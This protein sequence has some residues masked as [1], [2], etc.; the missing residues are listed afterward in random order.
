MQF[1][2]ISDDS[3]Y[4][5]VLVSTIKSR[6]NSLSIIPHRINQIVSKSLFKTRESISRDFPLIKIKITDSNDHSYDI[7]A[8][9][10]SGATSTY[11]SRTFVEDNQ[12]PTRKLTTNLYAYNA[13]DTLNSSVITH[14]AHF[15]CHIYGHQSRE[16]FYITD[17]G[18]KTMLIGMTWLRSHNPVINW[19]SGAIEFARC[20]KY[21][22]VIP[23]IQG[24]QQEIDLASILTEY[25]TEALNPLRHKINTKTNAATE[26][27]IEAFKTR[28]VLT[29]DDIKAGPLADYADVFEDTINHTLPPHRDFD[30]RIE[31]VDGWKHWRSYA[32]R[33]PPHHW[34]HRTIFVINN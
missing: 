28:K 32:Y 15:L 7:H 20:P 18:T 16:W 19:R 30:H 10:D 8:L 13:D 23:S 31:L 12:I 25:S 27:A 5:H 9:L 14:Q 17:L 34:V 1:R 33:P 3:D 4:L 2:S 6:I 26:W 29:I 24:V 21:C 22:G 11:I